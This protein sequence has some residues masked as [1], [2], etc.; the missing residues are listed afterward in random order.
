LEKNVNSN[1]EDCLKQLKSRDPV[2]I[3]LALKGL[4][5]LKDPAAV[6]EIKKFLD[7]SDKMI[8]FFAKKAIKKI[9]SPQK[10][11]SSGASS[12]TDES[13]ND[14]KKRPGL[15]ADPPYD[16]AP[17]NDLTDP[18]ADSPINAVRGKMPLKFP[19]SDSPDISVKHGASS[20][21]SLPPD[22]V[23]SNEHDSD[24]LSTGSTDSWLYN[25]PL[26]ELDSEFNDM[27]IKEP[28]DDQIDIDEVPEDTISFEDLL[29]DAG[30]ENT[31]IFNSPSPGSDNI[32]EIL[33]ES[34]SSDQGNP[35][36]DL[37]N[38][39]W[40]DASDDDVY[41]ADEDV[42]SADED[43][44]SADEDAFDMGM[45][46]KKAFSPKK[47]TQKTEKKDLSLLSGD[48][49]MDF[50]KNLDNFD[51]SVES[52]DIE[53]SD[54]SSSAEDSSDEDLS[55]SYSEDI[56][57]AP[58]QGDNGSSVF[59]IPSS[60]PFAQMSEVTNIDVSEIP[61]NN[62]VSG[63]NNNGMPDWWQ[64]D[65]AEKDPDYKGKPYSPSFGKKDK[66]SVKK[67]LKR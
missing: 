43:V 55:D 62:A 6:P 39:S 14:V 37:L 41:S 49:D 34:D 32:I 17:K 45:P 3:R 60:G 13:D 46:A 65:D 23:I 1:L 53:T 35:F 64:P 51:V 2:K 27:D 36:E 63:N 56:P 58:D 38:S 21:N 33:D 9:E 24:V 12:D 8:V 26:N 22:T 40:N 7:H 29:K 4:E 25:S 18:P 16:A 15:H 67:P 31:E 30:S 44:Y 52:D 20:N 48:N 50:F 42:Y 10:G 28:F 61:P 47:D 54:E 57:E 66:K 19:K 59:G 11:A 5:N